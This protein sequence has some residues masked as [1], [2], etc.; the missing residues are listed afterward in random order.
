MM[1]FAK[2]Q[3][4]RMMDFSS[5][6]AECDL[7]DIRF[8]AQKARQLSPVAVF[9]LPAWISVLRELLADKADVAIGGVV[10]FPSGGETTKSKVF[11]AKELVSIGCDE[12]DMVVNIGKLRSGRYGEVEDDIRKV[13]EA[14]EGKPVKVIL[15]CC[16]VTDDQSRDGCHS[17]VAAGAHFIK[18]GTG[19]ADCSRIAEYISLMYSCIGQE[20]GI[21]AAGG[22]RDLEMLIDLYNRG[23]RRFGVGVNSA[24]RILGHCKDTV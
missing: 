15:E 1:E 7:D 20:I 8:L 21:K 19:W 9:A 22:V 6:R 10:G 2:H 14:V 24:I 18:T 16:R 5:V 13:V 11:Q 17:C 12:I 23:A 3:V 4:A